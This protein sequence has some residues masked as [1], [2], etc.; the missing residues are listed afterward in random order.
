MQKKHSV[1]VINDKNVNNIR[2]ICF[3]TIL[4]ID[5]SETFEKDDINKIFNN[6]KYLIINADLDN[7]SFKII[8]D[9]NINIITYGFNQKSTITASSVEEELIICIQRKI[10]DINGK[11]IEPQE[12]KVKRIG[13]K[14]SNNVHNLMGI[15]SLLLI[16]GEKQLIF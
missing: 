10:R 1:I 2:N 12:I 8:N 6:T 11:M 15:A 5:F 4:I 9:L 14:L 7:E 16:Y 13:K 3:E